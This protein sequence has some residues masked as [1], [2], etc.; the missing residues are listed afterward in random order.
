MP[1]KFEREFQET[2]SPYV[3]YEEPRDIFKI[4]LPFAWIGK[5]H[6]EQK[7][8]PLLRRGAQ[9]VREFSVEV[10]RDKKDT[11]EAEEREWVHETIVRQKG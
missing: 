11:K 4:Y 7:V 8:E 1:G 5:H 2:P 9:Y 10:C 3:R 6:V